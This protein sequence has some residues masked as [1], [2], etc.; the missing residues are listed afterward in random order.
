MLFEEHTLSPRTK[1]SI[2]SSIF[3]RYYRFLYIP[4]FPIF[5][6]YTDICR[7]SRYFRRNFQFL[8]RRY[9]PDTRHF[10][11]CLSLTPILTFL[12]N[13]VGL[14]FIFYLSTLVCW[15]IKNN[16]LAGP[17]F[18]DIWCC[19][20]ETDDSCNFATTRIL[21]CMAESFSFFKSHSPT[22]TQPLSSSQIITTNLFGI[23]NILRG[24]YLFICISFSP[25]I[26]DTP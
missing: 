21:T 16:V 26:H 1:I 17:I 6:I 20:Y 22:P 4:I 15:L 24:F 8:N 10:G 3:R 2:I 19:V 25:Y 23:F 7:Y 9:F 12:S 13:S 18:I 5:S 11:R 14:K